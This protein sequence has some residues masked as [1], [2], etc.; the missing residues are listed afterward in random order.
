M[1]GRK[2]EYIVGNTVP[3]P[4]PE[5]VVKT[6]SRRPVK[7]FNEDELA[8]VVDKL[9]VYPGGNEKFQAFLDTSLEMAPYLAKDI[10]K[11]ICN[12]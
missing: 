12:D 1:I 6:K 8:K 11:N 7:E 4:E 2:G 10:R 5:P 9:P 3:E